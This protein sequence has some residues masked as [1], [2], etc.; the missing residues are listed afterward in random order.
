MDKNTRSKDKAVEDWLSR[1]ANDL[2]S[3]KV[4]YENRFFDNC[5]YHLQQSNEKL[6]KALLLSVGILTPKKAREDLT[7]QAFLGFL[8]KQPF[9]YGHRTTRFLISDL[10]KSVPSIEALLTRMK[11]SELGPRITG[12]LQEVRTS[13]KGL[14][15]LKKRTFGLIKTSEQL[16][17]EV[18]TAQ[19][20]LDA[21]DQTPKTAKAELDRLD[22]AELVRAATSLARS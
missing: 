8:P 15:K 5:V 3:A 2:E 6:A 21:L 14:K 1:S 11:N 7:V 9:A 10:E 19:A 4:L 20:I 16:E 22:S 18:K 17:I 13:E 12:F